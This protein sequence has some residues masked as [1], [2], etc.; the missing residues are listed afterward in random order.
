MYQVIRSNRKTL[1]LQIRPDGTLVVRAP[2][3]MSEREIREAVER[4][5]DWIAKHR[6]KA[7]AAAPEPV[8]LLSPEALRALADQALQ[9]IP[10][11]A[12]RYADRIGVSYGRITIRNQRS[13]WGSCSGQ[14][15]LNFNCLLMLCPR[16]VVEY[17]VVHELC[18][19]KQMNHSPAFWNE[20]AR[21]I[22][23]YRQKEAWLKQHG[24]AIL[25]RMT[26]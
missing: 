4:H 6:Q 21:V 18:H 17:V 8:D 11:I 25:R 23:D 1:G 5:S 7:V 13:K 20:V 3:R 15:N 24:A 22:P 9:V 14:G 19:R 16:D 10:P 2:L 12:A 26:G